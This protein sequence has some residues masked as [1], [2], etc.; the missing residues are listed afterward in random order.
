MDDRLPIVPHKT[1][2]QDVRSVGGER[3]AL[4]ALEQLGFESFLK[5]KGMS[6]NYRK[7]AIM[8]VVGRMLHPSSGSSS[9]MCVKGSLTSS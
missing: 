9:K 4:Q 2:L 8:L 6:L 5:S 1:R 3:V 7:I